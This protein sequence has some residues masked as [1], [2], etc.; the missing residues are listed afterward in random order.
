MTTAVAAAAGGWAPVRAPCSNGMRRADAGLVACRQTRMEGAEIN[1]SLLALK[2]CIRALDSEARHV[3]FRGSKL[4]EVPAPGALAASAGPQLQGHAC[5]AQGLLLS[6]C[7]L[8]RRRWDPPQA[9]PH[10]AGPPQDDLLSQ[11]HTRPAAI[12]HMVPPR[13]GLAVLQHLLLRCRCVRRCCV[14]PSWAPRP[15]RS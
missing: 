2:E 8:Y 10:S 15:G 7:S 14:T 13:C 4:T 9:P 5:L 11:P 12:W 1:K 6:C 3:P